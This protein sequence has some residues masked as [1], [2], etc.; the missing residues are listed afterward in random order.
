MNMNAGLLTFLLCTTPLAWAAGADA[1]ECQEAIDRYH[2][3]LSDVSDA[4]RQYARCVADSRGRDDCDSEFSA[5]R[6]AQ[7]DFESA[8]HQYKNECN[9]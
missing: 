3:K 7:D 6:N 2:H 9:Q 8:V 4:V 1:G 5:L